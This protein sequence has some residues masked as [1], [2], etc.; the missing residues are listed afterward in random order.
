MEDTMN[1]PDHLVD[2]QGWDGYWNQQNSGGIVYAWV[3]SFYR[4]FII[5]PSLNRF[6]RK[7]FA[8]GTELVHAGCG[9]GEVD[10]ELHKHFSLIGLDISPAAL[11][12]YK[13]NNGAAVKVVHGSILEMPFPD[14]SVAG[15]YNLGVVEHFEWKDVDTILAEFRRVLRPGGRIVI[16]WPPEYGLSVRFFKVARAVVRTLTGRDPKFHPDEVSR[17]E[18][19]AQ[20]RKAIERAGLRWIEYSFG[21]RDL[22][23]YSV[24]VAGKDSVS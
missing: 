10:A 11:R 12:L 8:P 5:R 4:R 18:S 13:K 20:A 17:L 22:W 21:A 3:A 1:L 9:T 23:T 2:K 15:I 24:V 6:I 16:F 7:Y 14:N 19:S